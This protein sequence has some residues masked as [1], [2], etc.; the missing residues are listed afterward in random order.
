[1]FSKDYFPGLS[2]STPFRSSS[3]PWLT[4]SQDSTQII[5]ETFFSIQIQCW[6]LSWKMPT[7]HDFAVSILN[8]CSPNTNTN[9]N[10]Y[11]LMGLYFYFIRCQLF[12]SLLY[13]QASFFNT[14][15]HMLHIL[16][17]FQKTKYIQHFHLIE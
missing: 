2:S 14:N 12:S 5:P 6:S 7:T 4:K 3:W 8:N 17:S 15:W 10:I 13:P 11:I 9:H 16:R 1:M